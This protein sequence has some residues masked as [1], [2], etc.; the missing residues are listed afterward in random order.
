MSR[1]LSTDLSDPDV[2]PYFLWDDAMTV[3]QLEAFLRTA[4]PDDR[5]RMLGKIVREAKDV[6]V[7]RFLTPADLE[8]DWNRIA[9][10]LGRRR[11]YW[12]WLLE[13]WRSQGLL[14]G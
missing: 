7:W 10:Y 3:S 13:G 9:P 6:D 1:R 4:S 11:S 12:Q 2:V 5:F 14:R 8:R